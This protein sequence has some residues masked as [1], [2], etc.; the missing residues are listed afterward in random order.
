MHVIEFEGLQ[1]YLKGF[2]NIGEIFAIL[3][4]ERQNQQQ[5]E[6][7]NHGLKTKK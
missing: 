7:Q 1:N 5:A 6:S 3:D 4:I 2:G